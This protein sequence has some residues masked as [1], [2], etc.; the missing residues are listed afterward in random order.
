M[1][2][3][4]CVRLLQWALPQMR[5]RWP[6]FRKVRRQV[7]RRIDRRLRELGLPDGDAYRAYLASHRAEWHVLDSFCR[8]SISRFY[9]DRGVFDVLRDELLPKLAWA[10][11][12]RGDRALCC[13]SAGCASGEEVYTVNMI[14]KLCVRR[15]FPDLALRLIATDSDPQMLARAR[16]ACYP[17]SSLKDLPAAWRA[18][19]LT[20]ADRLYC[21]KPEFRSGVELRQQDIR[22]NLPP[23]RFDLIFCRHLAFTYFDEPLQCRLLDALVGK[24]TPG[25]FLVTG[26]QEPLPRELPQL[27]EYGSR[28]GIYQKLTGVT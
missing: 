16:Q 5:M 26:K 14:W 17:A 15:R 6:G 4:E 28:L 3:P 10:A 21:L 9:R 19:A 18:I 12:R 1:K 22:S 23:E 25:G 7:C 24:L 11:R 27:D 2:D 8:I 20:P 13:W